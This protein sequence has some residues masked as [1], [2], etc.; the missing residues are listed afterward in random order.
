MSM[1]QANLPARLFANH[2]G[3]KEA[4]AHALQYEPE[5][6]KNPALRGLPLLIASA[7]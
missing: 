5:E 6:T 3:S 4:P 7:M 1:S 2:P